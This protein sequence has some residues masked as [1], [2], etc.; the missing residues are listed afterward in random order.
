MAAGDVRKTCLDCKYGSWD[1]YG[2]RAGMLIRNDDFLRC[3][4]HGEAAMDWQE[5]NGFFTVKFG[6]A[7]EE[8]P[9]ARSCPGFEQDTPLDLDAVLDAVSGIRRERC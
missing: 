1:S 7:S 9:D 8:M 3:E 6:A 4:A 5:E 2:E